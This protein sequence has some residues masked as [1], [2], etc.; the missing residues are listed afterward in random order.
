M[1]VLQKQKYLYQ[2]M[3]KVE[4]SLEAF[5]PTTSTIIV[6]KF[7][8][9]LHSAGAIPWTLGELNWII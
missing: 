3:V 1:N 2:R 6:H 9:P 8:L 5:Q 7:Q 4:I